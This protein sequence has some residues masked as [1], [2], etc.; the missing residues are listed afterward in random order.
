MKISNQPTTYSINGKTITTRYRIILPRNEYLLKLARAKRK[1]GIPA[2]II[3]WQAVSGNQFHKIDFDRQK[4]IGN[5]IVDFYVKSLSLV[6]EID[7][8]SHKEKVE[9]DRKRTDYFIRLG[10]NVFRVEDGE[11]RRHLKL[12]LSNLEDYLIENYGEEPSPALGHP[13]EEGS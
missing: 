1:E 6:V 4:V 2:E 3:F 5:Y 12:V 11:V 7:G 9:Y 8:R 13:S 10:L